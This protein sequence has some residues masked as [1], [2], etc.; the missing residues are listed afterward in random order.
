MRNQLFCVLAF[1]AAVLMLSGCGHGCGDVTGV[2]YYRNKPLEAGTISFF[3][4]RKGVHSSEINADGSYEVTNVAT[5]IA[6][7][8]VVTPM[9]ITLPGMTAAKATPI[10]AK[11]ADRE[12]SGL[13]CN[14]HRGRQEHTVELVD[15]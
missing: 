11:Y 3:D 8:S 10:P 7:L 9:P 14:V 2:V 6:K 15:P 12:K 1:W 5:G 13:T 4:E